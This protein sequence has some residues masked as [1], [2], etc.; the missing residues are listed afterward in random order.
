MLLSITG[1]Y[2]LTLLWGNTTIPAPS[3]VPVSSSHKICRPFRIFR[4]TCVTPTTGY[5]SILPELESRDKWLPPD[6][7]DLGIRIVFIIV[8]Q[9]R[10]KMEWSA[11]LTFLSL[12]FLPATDGAANW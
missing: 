4:Q 11:V 6:Y 10:N 3:R 1:H 5:A 12:A 8:H 9:G 2:G 7:L